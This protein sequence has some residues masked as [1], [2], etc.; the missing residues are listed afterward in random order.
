LVQGR[1][2]WLFAREDIG[3]ERVAN[4]LTILATCIAHDVNPRAYLH[5]VS[6]LIVRGWPQSK[7]AELLPDQLRRM[8][9]EL[10]LL[11]SE[12]ELLLGA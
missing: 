12:D 4:I 5:L 1:K 10:A 6:K 3:G 8:H 9:P 2:N 7:L 11:P